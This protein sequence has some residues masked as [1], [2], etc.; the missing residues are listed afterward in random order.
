[1]I[2]EII[3]DYLTTALQGI[4]VYMVVPDIQNPDGATY[5]AVE[6]TGGGMENHIKNATIA[7]QS[8]A[9][10]LYGAMQLNETVKTAMLDIVTEQTIAGVRLNSDYNFT[11]T[12]TKQPRYQAVF[13]V[14]YY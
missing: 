14:Y 1:M 3:Y 12:S 13:I 8:Y 6:K 10:T 5:V 4:P 7:V 11:D 2:E 9:P